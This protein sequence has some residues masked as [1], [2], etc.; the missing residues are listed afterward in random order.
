MPRTSA[1]ERSAS[2]YRAGR[3]SMPP[4]KVLSPRAKQIWRQIVGAKPID[5]FDGGNH[6]Y[7]ADHCEEQARLEAI[8]VEL[9]EVVPGS[10]ESAR[11]TAEL[12][13]IRGNLSTS[14]RHL[15]LTV[16]EAIQRAA[17][18]A[19]ERQATASGDQLI[20]GAA[21]KGPRIRQ[22]V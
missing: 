8:W 18:K 1:E 13:T 15:R 14:A 3:K 9:R 2:F 17:T 12:K 19:G 4:P 20:G 22:V 16:Q 7:L 10:P 5:W 21:V 6:G 11:L